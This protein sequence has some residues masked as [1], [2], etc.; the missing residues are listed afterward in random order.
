MAF[1]RL[2]QGQ[3][4][5]KREELCFEVARECKGV[6]FSLPCLL[7]L[8]L[9]VLLLRS[10]SA[11]LESL[12]RHQRRKFRFEIQK[13]HH[14]TGTPIAFLPLADLQRHQAICLGHQPR[15]FQH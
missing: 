14:I 12:G 5:Q 6:A 9:G 15:V 10:L 4:A 11:A 8:L 2:E 7:F 13:S 1:Q 3:A